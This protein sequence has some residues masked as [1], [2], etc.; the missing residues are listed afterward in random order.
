MMWK[1]SALLIGDMIRR[2]IP[3]AGAALLP[4]A[5]F[6]IISGCAR[7]PY[8]TEYPFT[9]PLLASSDG[10]LRFAVP[11]GWFD[12]TANAKM[13]RTV[14]WI[15]RNDYGASIS[16][17]P[18]DIDAETRRE[19]K[20]AGLMRIAR[21][22]MQLNMNV[23]SAVILQA[24]GIGRSGEREYCAYEIEEPATNDR[25]RVVLFDTGE[26]LYEMTALQTA[27]DRSPANRE[28]YTIQ[29]RFLARLQW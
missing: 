25:M 5:L 3:G 16:I 2:Y 8:S 24:P 9:G 1:K 22:S 26:D 19:V 29:E 4:A 18:I 12:A 17:S 6:L 27:G 14:V 20:H 13:P 7:P 28:V 11:V 15:V 21:L 10:H 23:R